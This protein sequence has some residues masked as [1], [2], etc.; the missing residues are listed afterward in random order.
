MDFTLSRPGL[1][2][3]T[4]DASIALAMSQGHLKRQMDSKGGPLIA[5]EDYFLGAHKTSPIRWDVESCREKF[6]QLGMLSRK[7]QA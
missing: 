5:G 2:L 7:E 6:H 4:G 1:V 3:K